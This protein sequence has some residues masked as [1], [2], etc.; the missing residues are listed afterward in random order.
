MKT[1][2]QHLFQFYKNLKPPVALPNNIQWLYPQQA[3]EVLNTVQTFLKKYYSDAAPRSLL[4][5]INPG[6]F[7]AGVTG[8]N[9]TAAKQLTE[10]CG[11]QHPF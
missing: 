4:L 8:V 1:W 2:A 5:G 11:L 7:G 3:P 6:R 9:F 10:E